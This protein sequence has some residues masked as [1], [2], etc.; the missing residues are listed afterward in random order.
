MIELSGPSSKPWT[1]LDP[2]TAHAVRHARHSGMREPNRR[3]HTLWDGRY[4]GG[5]LSAF[6]H[7]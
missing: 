6:S 4:R 1:G 2:K 7:I 3:L 5:N